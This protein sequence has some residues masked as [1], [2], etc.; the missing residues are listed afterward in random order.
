MG[1]KRDSPRCCEVGKYNVS[2]KSWGD[3]DGGVERDA[4]GLKSRGTC[5]RRKQWEEGQI[6]HDETVQE[7]QFSVIGII[8]VNAGSI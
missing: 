5:E 1:V 8:K 3:G 6:L 2:A 4:Q 7:A